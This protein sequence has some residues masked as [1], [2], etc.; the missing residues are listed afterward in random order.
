[1]FHVL[2]HKQILQTSGTLLH[3]SSFKENPISAKL[4]VSKIFQPPLRRTGEIWAA[5]ALMPEVRH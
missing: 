5:M 2:S 1:M 3:Q 4:S